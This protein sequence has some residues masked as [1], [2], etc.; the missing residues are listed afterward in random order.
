MNSERLGLNT[1]TPS[2][3]FLDLNSAFAS[4]EQLYR[5]ELRGRPVSATGSVAGSGR[6][7]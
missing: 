3:L 5:P 7:N 4:I 2:V 1:A 6:T